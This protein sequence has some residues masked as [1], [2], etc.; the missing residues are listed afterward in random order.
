MK[1][2]LSL[3]VTFLKHKDSK[4]L[5][6]F[7]PKTNKEFFARWPAPDPGLHELQ[8]AGKSLNIEDLGHDEVVRF[9]SRVYVVRR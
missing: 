1:Y 4:T 3:R 8:E 5:G 7:W 2:M 9:I 6:D